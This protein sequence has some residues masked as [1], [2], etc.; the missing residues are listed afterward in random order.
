MKFPAASRVVIVG[1]LSLCALPGCQ[2][3]KDFAAAHGLSTPSSD[4]VSLIQ[5][6]L[7]NLGDLTA[8]LNG[9]TT[10]TAAQT[11]APQAASKLDTIKSLAA[12]LSGLSTT[13]KASLASSYGSKL[14]DAIAKLKSAAT[15]A[16]ANPQAA[17]SLG[18]ILQNIDYKQ[19]LPF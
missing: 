4:A 12:K 8:L 3:T 13:D 17:P 14:S 11:A 7:G 1:F 9:A 18:S 19:L 15:S 5:S 2:A 6:Y 10:T 16:S